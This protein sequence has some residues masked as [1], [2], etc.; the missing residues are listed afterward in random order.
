M[1]RRPQAVINGNGRS[2]PSK[3]VGTGNLDW[4]SFNQLIDLSGVRQYGI[5]PDKIT[6][7]STDSDI[8]A[9]GTG[10]LPGPDVHASGQW[11]DL[12]QERRAP[13]DGVQR[14]GE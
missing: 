11:R 5:D 4:T 10:E 2:R 12:G 14:H 1:S 8:Y 6:I 7:G 13:R 9:V 3:V